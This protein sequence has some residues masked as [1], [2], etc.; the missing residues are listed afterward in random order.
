MNNLRRSKPGRKASANCSP[1]LLQRQ[2]WQDDRA[3]W[4]PAAETAMSV[5]MIEELFAAKK[6]GIQSTAPGDHQTTCPRC[7]HLRK[8]KLDKCLSVK[9][10]DDGVCWHCHH[11]GWDGPQKGQGNGQ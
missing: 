4:T 6:I 5:M 3:L 1:N 9:I 10:D 8:K 7:S 11:C 2:G